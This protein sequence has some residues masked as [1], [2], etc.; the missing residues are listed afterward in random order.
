MKTLVRL[1]TLFFAIGLLILGNVEVSYGQGGAAT[2]LAPAAA[3]PRIYIGP[4]GGF[5]QDFHSGGFR[6][7]KGDVA[8]PVF[9]AASATGFFAGLSFEYF[10]GS[11]PAEATSSLLFRLAYDTRPVSFAVREEGTATLPV[12]DTN[13]QKIVDVTTEHRA[14]IAYSLISFD[15]LYKI[16]IS[17]DIPIG[18]AA[19]PTANFVVTGTVKQTYEIVEPLNAQFDTTKGK[20]RGYRYEQNGQVL[21]IQDGDIPE[22][23]SFRFGLKAGLFFELSL[24]KFLFAPA[25]VVPGIWFDAGLTKVT[26]AENW[27]VNAFQAGIDVRWAL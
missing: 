15:A 10:L 21:V 27:R 13:L 17:K 25:L 9:E 2:P 11:N 16:M 14:K 5:N 23:V 12:I 8:C 3:P 18:I 24:R 22:R 20:S 7:F 19:G 26:S 4:I 6:S 1:H